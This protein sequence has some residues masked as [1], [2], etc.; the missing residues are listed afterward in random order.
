MSHSFI[1]AST[2]LMITAATFEHI[3]FWV[4]VSAIAA[5]I[6]YMAFWR[7]QMLDRIKSFERRFEALDPEG[8]KQHQRRLNQ[9]WFNTKS[10]SSDISIRREHHE[11]R[12][13]LWYFK[14]TPMF[15]LAGITL[16]LYVLETVEPLIVASTQRSV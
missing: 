16:L 11:F 1:I 13:E 14:M 8:Y 9:R 15:L 12:I 10:R 7:W 4:M 5:A 3:R 2:P 6:T